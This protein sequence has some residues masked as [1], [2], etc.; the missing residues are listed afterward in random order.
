[1]KDSLHILCCI[2]RS[3]VNNNFAYIIMQ[4]YTELTAIKVK[5]LKYTRNLIS[6]MQKKLLLHTGRHENN[7]DRMGEKCG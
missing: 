1:M 4:K 2:Y 6:I 7:V 3:V 5:V